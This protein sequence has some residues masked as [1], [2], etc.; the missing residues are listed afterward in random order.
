[1]S[2]NNNTMYTLV[3][4]TRTYKNTCVFVRD[5]RVTALRV[6]VSSSRIGVGVNYFPCNTYTKRK[7]L[8]AGRKRTHYGTADLIP[9]E[10]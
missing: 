8:S 9:R 5:R 6:S 3:A 2:R 7:I 1:M 4:E 10:I